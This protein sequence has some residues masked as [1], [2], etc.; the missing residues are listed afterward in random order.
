MTGWTS[1]TGEKSFHH[2]IRPLANTAV[3]Y[4]IYPINRMSASPVPIQT[5]VIPAAAAAA[6]SGDDDAVA[7]SCSLRLCKHT[8]TRD[9][10]VIPCAKPTC[11]KGMHLSCFTS[12]YK[13]ADFPKLVQNV[14]IV[15]TKG[16]YKAVASPMALTWRNDGPLGK[17]KEGCSEAILLDWLT[18]EGNYALYRGG[19][20]TKGK[21]ENSA[22][23]I[24]RIINDK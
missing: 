24:A 15:C 10:L 7:L 18:E 19:P 14:Q 3:P 22:A 12:K 16:C 9:V 2:T 6:A 11:P 13:Y 8:A 21:K 20:Q 4:H 1:G 17:E 23:Q 5:L